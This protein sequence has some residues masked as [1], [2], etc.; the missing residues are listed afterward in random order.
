[1][2]TK[3]LRTDYSLRTNLA[4]REF[5]HQPPVHIHETDFGELPGVTRNNN[6]AGVIQTLADILN[7]PPVKVV[8][9]VAETKLDA[10]DGVMEVMTRDS[11]AVVIASTQCNDI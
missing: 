2:R 1:M 4:H 5:A 9:V 7:V 10:P 3:V 6:V 8:S 11:R